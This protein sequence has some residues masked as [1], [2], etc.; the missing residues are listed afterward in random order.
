LT[1]VLVYYCKDQEQK[2]Y[3]VILRVRTTWFNWRPALGK[4]SFDPEWKV[5][6]DGSPFL[7]DTHPVPVA[8]ATRKAVHV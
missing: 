1:C 2:Y 6:Q 4:T 8:I 5:I 3:L 7:G